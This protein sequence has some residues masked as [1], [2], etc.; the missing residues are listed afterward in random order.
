L[1]EL[2]EVSLWYN[3]ITEISWLSGVTSLATL[4]LGG[5]QIT[6]ISVL[7]GLP[8]LK[9]IELNANKIH[10]ISPLMNLHNLRNLLL[11]ENPLDAEACNVYIPQIRVNNP[12]INL[13]YDACV[14]PTVRA[15][16]VS[17]L[18]EGEAADN[19]PRI[20]V[21][22]TDDGGE[23][24][25][26][27]LRYKPDGGEYSYTDW[28]WGPLATGET[29]WVLVSLDNVIG[30]TGY[31]CNAQ[32][33]NSAG[34]GAWSNESSFFTFCPTRTLT[35]SA[36]E[37]GH[38]T[39]PAE[40]AGSYQ[41]PYCGV[42]T[43][44]ATPDGCYEFTGWTGWPV[45][46]GWVADPSAPET[47]VMVYGEGGLVANFAPA[48]ETVTLTISAGPHGSLVEP[49]EGVH[50]HCSG[51]WVR[52][53]AKA[54]P[55]YHFVRWFGASD[56]YEN[57]TSQL[58]TGDYE[59]TAEFTMDRPRLTVSATDG[60]RI[61]QPAKTDDQ[62]DLGTPVTVTVEGTSPRFSWV[63]WTGTAVD[64]GKVADPSTL[65][66]TVVVDAD[67]TLKAV[68]KYNPGPIYVGVDAT[69]ELEDGT[70]D[71][72][73]HTIQ[74]GVDA[75]RDGDTIIIRDGTYKGIGNRDI[76][77]VGK[78]ITMRS[79][80]GSATCTI[81]CESMSGA[82]TIG[83]ADGVAVQG[84]GITNGRADLHAIYIRHD[85][86]RASIDGCAI[87]QRGGE[88]I[89]CEGDEPT[90][91]GCNFKGL[92]EAVTV[93]LGAGT[94]WIKDSEFTA[95]NDSIRSWCSGTARL[96]VERCNFHDNADDTSSLDYCAINQQWGAA[97]IIVQNCTFINNSMW[98]QVGNTIYVCY[99]GA[100]YAPNAR[101]VIDRSHFERNRGM[102]GAIVA[103]DAEVTN[104]VF[105][106]N[107]SWPWFVWSRD[108]AR[109]TLQVGNL[110]A[111]N[112][113]IVNN[114]GKGLE[115]ATLDLRN[116]IAWGNGRTTHNWWDQINGSSVMSVDYSCV[117]GASALGGEGNFG[118]DP[119]LLADGYH[120]APDS[121]CIDAGDPTFVGTGEMDIDNQPR[122][123]GDHVDIG[124]DEHPGSGTLLVEM[125][126]VGVSSFDSEAD[127]HN[128]IE[129]KPGW[130]HL[131]GGLLGGGCIAKYSIH[132][133][134]PAKLEQLTRVRVSVSGTKHW[135]AE[136]HVYILPDTDNRY[137]IP[138]SGEVEIIDWRGEQVK[139]APLALPD[140][141]T[142][143]LQVAISTAPAG[144][145]VEKIS[146]WCEYDTISEDVL[147]RFTLAYGA[148]DAFNM[149]EEG[150]RQLWNP[151]AGQA[152]FFAEGWYRTAALTIELAMAL[153][154]GAVSGAVA[155]T[156]KSFFDDMLKIGTNAADWY[157]FWQPDG[158]GNY[159]RG[160]GA[161]VVGTAL[162]TVETSIQ[163]YLTGLQSSA[164]DGIVDA[165]DATTLNAKIDAIVSAVTSLETQM[166]NAFNAAVDQ[167]NKGCCVD[168]LFTGEKRVGCTKTGK[169]IIKSLSP[170]LTPVYDETTKTWSLTEPSML[171]DFCESLEKFP[172]DG[173]SAPAGQ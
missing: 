83:H 45:D 57:P 80:N 15:P 159:Y 79:E 48:G 122:I 131:G 44:A 89:S 31:W 115:C 58:M 25:W 130:I 137:D 16:V 165:T 151:I 10:D 126:G 28:S 144:Y 153:N 77:I 37:G 13:S 70:P 92:R 38:I 95:N 84:L 65:S 54:D 21:K 55:H 155:N 104:S 164:F 72:P 41:Y 156:W 32:G 74:E 27:R 139:D 108:E 134:K 121:P 96:Y 168:D 39:M 100:I 5:N 136:T 75:A 62:Y 152:S 87:E 4:E 171:D 33:R 118:N 146:V 147:Q 40:G 29:V 61:V 46:L 60:G 107:W 124:A 135:P 8:N 63:G 35:I 162:D 148:L 14:E 141:Y 167:Y 169:I 150:I 163:D 119:K 101:L 9:T 82:I 97:E 91:S 111:T 105:I 18:Q 93:N 110:K 88:G 73:Y 12:G 170:L 133:P 140:T 161:S 59:I 138:D 71:H 81:D 116:S 53:E 114:S 56:P 43:V 2:L 1:T 52:L 49:E 7:A 132:I 11:Q 128:L 78:S 142:Y 129:S 98:S 50:S 113:S 26:V 109:A 172:V 6:D 154:K 3:Q 67:Y 160:P 120:L 47:T 34:E 145:D 30:C 123:I 112:C 69:H 103:S 76:Q 102:H 166:S 173:G 36:T 19:R 149:Y 24:A 85:A 90:I 20:L 158:C 51:T 23:G 157:Y 94:A 17:I 117:Q 106:S 125:P 42:A 66:I 22:V 86:P 64:A 99:A 127:A 143:E 68:F